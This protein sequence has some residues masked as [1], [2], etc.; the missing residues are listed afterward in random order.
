MGE[1]LIADYSNQIKRSNTLKRD[2]RKA[3]IKRN[4]LTRKIKNVPIKNDYSK[5]YN[6]TAIFFKT[7]MILV[8][9]RDE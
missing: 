2:I 1:L 9:S 6:Y 7:L 8:S 3:L 5:L 4:R